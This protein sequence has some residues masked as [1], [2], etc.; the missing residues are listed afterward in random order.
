[1]MWNVDVDAK[2]E[3]R[4]H[5]TTSP[6]ASCDHTV[7]EHTNNTYIVEFFSVVLRFTFY[8]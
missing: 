2:A 5:I 6:H 7:L 4:R 1:M 8:G 3:V